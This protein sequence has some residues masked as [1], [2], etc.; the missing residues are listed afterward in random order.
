MS[1]IVI[2][3][4][5]EIGMRSDI[6]RIIT[7]E[8]V[9]KPTQDYKPERKKKLKVQWPQARLVQSVQAIGTCTLTWIGSRVLTGMGISLATELGKWEEWL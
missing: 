2:I 8:L 3:S 5:G 7:S 9:I 1:F 6:L 4:P